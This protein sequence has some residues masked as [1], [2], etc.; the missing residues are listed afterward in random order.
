MI[1]VKDQVVNAIQKTNKKNK[2]WIGRLN[3][4]LY[5]KAM[6]KTDNFQLIITFLF[7]FFKSRPCLIRKTPSCVTGA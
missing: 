1:H 4:L 3:F 6:K 2:Q 7:F 5:M